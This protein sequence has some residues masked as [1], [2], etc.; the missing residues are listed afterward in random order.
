MTIYVINE[1][2]EEGCVY[3]PVPVPG[4][5]QAQQYGGQCSCVFPLRKAQ[6]HK[7]DAPHPGLASAGVGKHLGLG[8]LQGP[9]MLQSG[10]A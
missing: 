9:G 10:T 3:S 6:R 2:I 1:G 4:R 7:D 5:V 8:T